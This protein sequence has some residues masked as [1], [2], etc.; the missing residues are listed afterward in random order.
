[1]KVKFAPGKSGCRYS[2]FQVGWLYPF[3]QH[4][5]LCCPE[6]VCVNSGTSLVWGILV[7]LLTILKENA[8]KDSPGI[9]RIQ[10]SLNRVKYDRVLVKFFVSEENSFYQENGITDFCH[11]YRDMPTTSAVVSET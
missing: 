2:G 1:M 5:A 9:N 6:M 7:D 10:T 11:L 8:I 4:I 3:C